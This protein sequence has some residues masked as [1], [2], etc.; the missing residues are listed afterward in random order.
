M[1]SNDRRQKGKKGN[2]KVKKK[3]KRQEEWEVYHN[4]NFTV[5]RWQRKGERVFYNCRIASREKEL[6]SAHYCCK[7]HTR[8]D[9]DRG[10]ELFLR[11]RHHLDSDFRFDFT[12]ELLE[13][14]STHQVNSFGIPIISACKKNVFSKWSTSWIHQSSTPRLCLNMVISSKV[15]K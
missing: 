2:G 8:V 7:N 10:L 14:K 4:H 13:I 6:P 12:C 1:E 3:K 5:W 11:L 15:P 9:K